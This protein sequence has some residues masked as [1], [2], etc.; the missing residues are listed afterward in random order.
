MEPDSVLRLN[1]TAGAVV[2]H[3]RS[4]L[5]YR[6]RIVPLGSGAPNLLVDYQGSGP[7]IVEGAFT[8]AFLAPNATLLLA[9]VN[10]GPHRGVF[11]AR[12]VELAASAVVRR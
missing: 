2:V 9:R 6:G 12:R 4:S 5:V 10:A 11:A 7:A 3:V 1:Q 8:G